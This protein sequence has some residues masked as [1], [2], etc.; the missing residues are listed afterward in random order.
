[1][2]IAELDEALTLAL[3]LQFTIGEAFRAIGG[4]G[5]PR[6]SQQQAIGAALRAR[7][8]DKARIM[9]HG[10]QQMR[11]SLDAAAAEVCIE[12]ARAAW[13]IASDAELKARQHYHALQR[14]V[15]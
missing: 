13:Q 9:F 2:N 12:H 11:W 7:G 8:Y 3:P 14:A 4:E 5:E 6:R 1:M 10:V 15:R